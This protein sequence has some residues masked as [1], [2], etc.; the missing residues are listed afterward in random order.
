[1]ILTGFYPHDTSKE[2]SLPEFEDKSVILAT[3]NFRIIEDVG[4]NNERKPV[5]K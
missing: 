3:G 1:V 5:L 4:Q 2:L